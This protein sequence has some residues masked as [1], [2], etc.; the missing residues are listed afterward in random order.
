MP[1]QKSEKATL[2]LTSKARTLNLRERAALFLTDGV[3]TRQDIQNQLSD[4]GGILDKLIAEGYLFSLRANTDHVAPFKKGSASPVMPAP[5]APHLAIQPG[6]ASA[7][8]RVH[9]LPVSA[10]TRR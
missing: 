10:N 5:V 1:L 4:D 2:E 3:K 6:P 7:H 8:P 9:L